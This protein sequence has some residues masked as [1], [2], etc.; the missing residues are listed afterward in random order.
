MVV[1]DD[2]FLKLFE[3]AE[4]AEQE[5]CYGASMKFDLFKMIRNCH[6]YSLAYFYGLELRQIEIE[7]KTVYLSRKAIKDQAIITWRLVPIGYVGTLGASGWRN[8]KWLEFDAEG[9]SKITLY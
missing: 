4:K 6:S 3:M 2:E 9:N 1:S 8:A 5:G 7:G